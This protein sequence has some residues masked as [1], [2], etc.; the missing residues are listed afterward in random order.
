MLLD[1]AHLWVHFADQ[2]MPGLRNLFDARGHSVELLQ[3]RILALGNATHPPKTDAPATETDPREHEEDHVTARAR[4]R[5]R[6]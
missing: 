1:F 2:I 6:C 3:H 5:S 4:L